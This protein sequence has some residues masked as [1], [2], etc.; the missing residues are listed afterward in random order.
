MVG[1]GWGATAAASVMAL[2]A[3]CSGHHRVSGL[4]GLQAVKTVDANWGACL[5]LVYVPVS[6]ASGGAADNGGRTGILISLARHANFFVN[7]PG[8]PDSHATPADQNTAKLLAQ[9][10][11]IQPDCIGK[12]SGT[13][14][15]YFAGSPP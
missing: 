4:T 5:K 11:A 6:H 10:E 2:A 14:P 13:L 9:A 15:P 3:A 7:D 8:G 12:R 1:R